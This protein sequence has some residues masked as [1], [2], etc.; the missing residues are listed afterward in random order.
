M[1]T[2]EDTMQGAVLYLKIYFCGIIFLLF[3]N[4]GAAILRA[5]GDTRKPLYYLIVC[6]ALNTVLDLLLVIVFDLGVFGVAAATVFSQAIS[7]LLVL[8]ALL[9]TDDIYRLSVRRI[10]ICG[11]SLTKCCGSAFPWGCRRSCTA[12]QISSYKWA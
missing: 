3:Y 5:V 4:V 11:D 8:I 2:P 6:C 7:A 12:R 10:A 1:N 9:R